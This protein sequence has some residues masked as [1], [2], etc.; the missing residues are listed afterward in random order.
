MAGLLSVLLFSRLFGMGILWEKLL[1]EDY[2]RTVKKYG[3]RR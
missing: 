3:G 1:G 2:N